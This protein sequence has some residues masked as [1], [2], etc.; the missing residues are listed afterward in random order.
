MYER[1]RE[2]GGGVEFHT[3]LTGFHQD[4]H[5]V[6]A[7]V[8]R[9]AGPDETIRAAYVIAADGGRSTVRRLTSVAMSGHTVDPLPILVADVRLA[10][11]HDA[12]PNAVADALGTLHPAADVADAAKGTS[13]AS[14]A[15]ASGSADETAGPGGA[16]VTEGSGWLAGR[17]PSI[18]PQEVGDSGIRRIGDFDGVRTRA[19]RLAVDLDLVAAL[20]EKGDLF[21]VRRWHDTIGGRSAS[22]RSGSTSRTIWRSTVNRTRRI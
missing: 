1:L 22:G 3:R 6:S 16:E 19:Q 11:A 10:T 13:A 14:R 21:L 9:S 20:D 17:A 8:T 5:G 12:V 18:P 15:D 7:T 4:T 2:L